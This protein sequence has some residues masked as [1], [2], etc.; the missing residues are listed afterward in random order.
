MN[1]TEGAI[2]GF[3]LIVV[4]GDFDHGSKQ[5]IRNAVDDILLGPYPPRGLL[6]D[7]TDCSFIDS[8]G[9]SVLLSV[10]ELLPPAGWLGLVGAST[11]TCR[12]L[13]YTGFLDLDKVRF[14]SSTSDAAATLAREER[15]RRM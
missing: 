8:G 1:V 6:V 14:F 13:T 5:A 3:P 9:L 11:G 2:G 12:V 10:L 4:E 7:L 15:L